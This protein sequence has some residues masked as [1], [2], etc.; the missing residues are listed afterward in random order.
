MPRRDR[1][2]RA[3]DR[4]ERLQRRRVLPHR[5]AV[6]AASTL[7]SLASERRQRRQAPRDR[8]G[9]AR[10][11][12]GGAAGAAVETPAR[13]AQMLWLGDTGRS[14]LFTPLG[15]TFPEASPWPLPEP[16][17]NLPAGAASPPVRARP[18]PKGCSSPS[19]PA[20]RPRLGWPPAAS[21][22]R[23][24]GRC[25]SERRAR[26]R[27]ALSSAGTPTPPTHPSYSYTDNPTPA[28]RESACRD[29]S[30]HAMPRLA[31]PRSTSRRLGWR[32]APRRR[33]WLTGAAAA[34]EGG[35]GEADRGGARC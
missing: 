22:S 7:A 26:Q 12:A 28:C 23:L 13:H 33:R 20:G 18:P 29:V 10:R 14:G 11:W 5:R 2:A 30:P 17:G 4:R 15:C 3:A 24:E 27:H 16:S 21:A 1:A 32:S 35:A 8:A 6:G 34:A 25:R 31:P 9:A 19:T